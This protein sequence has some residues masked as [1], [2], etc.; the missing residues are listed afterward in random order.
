MNAVVEYAIHHEG[1]ARRILL[2][3][4]HIPPD[5]LEDVVQDIYLRLLHSS[6]CRSGSVDFPISYWWATLRSVAREHWR[7]RKVRGI[8]GPLVA[9]YADPYP[10][11]ETLAI[12]RQE[13]REVL[14]AVRPSEREALR[15]YVLGIPK[16][17]ASRV[18]MHRLRFR[19]RLQ[20]G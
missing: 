11:P 14:T 18:T 19:L 20:G 12:Q 17:N 3:A 4:F 16:S 8:M 9:D 7:R 6:E 10:G 13:L 2:G 15:D 5:D 1:N